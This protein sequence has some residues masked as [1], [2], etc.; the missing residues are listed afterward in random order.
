[1]WV[2]IVWQLLAGGPGAT[3]T[4]FTTG[5]TFQEFRTEKTCNDAKERVELVNRELIKSWPYSGIL[6][7]ECVQK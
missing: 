3:T 4:A 1:M 6:R 7:M 5:V 2:L